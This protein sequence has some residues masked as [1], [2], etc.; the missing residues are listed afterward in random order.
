MKLL[1]RFLCLS[2]LC[3]LSPTG[4]G[5][6][7]VLVASPFPKELLTAYK[8]AFDEQSPDYRVEFVNFPGA[9]IISFLRDRAPGSRPDVF[10]AS[11]PDAFSAL[12]R[13]DLLLPLK[14]AGNPDIPRTVGKITIN[15][16]KGFYFGQALAGYGIMWNRR[17][18]DARKIRPPQTWRDLGEPEYAGHIIMSSPS[19]SSTTH[20]IVES[21]LQG[22]GW[23]EGWAL[24]LKIAGN[25]ATITERT[26]D[27]PNSITRGRFG[28]GPVVDFLALS[29]KYSGF[30]VDFVYAWPSVVT[31][32]SIGLINGARNPDGG[33]AFIEFT[34]SEAGQRL[35][36]QPEVSRLPVLPSLYETGYRPDDFP[37][38]IDITH[39]HLPTYA[40]DISESRYQLVG[41][42]F[43]QLVTFRHR[44]LASISRAIQSAE[45]KLRKQPDAEAARMIKEAQALVYRAPIDAD[46]ALL[47]ALPRNPA[48]R[49]SVIAA[50][51]VEWA[52]QR[53]KDLAQATKRIKEAESLL[54]RKP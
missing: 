33:R 38:L 9:N 5:A 41:A 11:S 16:P 18:L 30:P 3:L 24:I 13:S 7:V 22:T 52:R 46:D 29:G 34:L 43:D 36:L 23:N 15:D 1:K 50:H 21:I 51:E 26:F 6:S 37:T 40:P 17:Y 42:I 53:D 8:R 14:N 48:D 32:A 39:S 35:L 4:W 25:C 20:L 31:P 27:V 2:F 28:L 54:N 12:R 49:V 47:S 19:R 44:K 10:W 45:N